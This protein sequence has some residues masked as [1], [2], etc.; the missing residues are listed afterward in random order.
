MPQREGEEGGQ[1]ACLEGERGGERGVPQK[2]GRRRKGCVSR[3]RGGE[4][5]GVTSK[6]GHLVK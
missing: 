1:R 5:R 4:E 6:V 3:R 2:K